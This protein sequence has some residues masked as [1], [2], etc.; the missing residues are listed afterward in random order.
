MPRPKAIR[1]RIHYLRN[2]DIEKA[3]VAKTREQIQ[4]PYYLDFI[5]MALFLAFQE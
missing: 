1:Q 2:K 5:A 3:P 4:I